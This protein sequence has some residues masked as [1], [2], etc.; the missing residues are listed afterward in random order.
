M[1]ST[2]PAVTSEAGITLVGPI[3]LTGT[4]FSRVGLRPYG[5]LGLADLAPVTRNPVR[6]LP[7]MDLAA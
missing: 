1:N 3:P 4:W 5:L 2:T 6:S 7:R